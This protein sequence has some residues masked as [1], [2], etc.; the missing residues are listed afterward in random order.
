M[1][2][3]QHINLC[4]FAVFLF[5]TF[6]ETM[7]DVCIQSR[8]FKHVSLFSEENCIGKVHLDLHL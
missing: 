1:L 8:L 6:P 4:Y 5:R 3:V 2:N 7:I